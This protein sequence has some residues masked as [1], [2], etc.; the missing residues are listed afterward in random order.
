M[1][2]ALIIFYLANRPTK[3]YKS[4]TATNPPATLYPQK[5]IITLLKNFLFLLTNPDTNTVN[6]NSHYVNAIYNAIGDVIGGDPEPGLGGLSR[7][8][9]RLQRHVRARPGQVSPLQL[10]VRLRLHGA[11]EHA[12]SVRQRPAH[13]SQQMPHA[14][15]GLPETAGAQAQADRSLPRCFCESNAF[16]CSF[17]R[18]IRKFQ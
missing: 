9:L 5:L 18:Y 8:P 2:F 3:K 15:A 10:Q 11:G 13:L 14:H 16:A 7:H 6:L 1:T 17:L 12:A 4:S